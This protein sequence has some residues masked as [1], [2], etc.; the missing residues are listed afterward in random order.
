MTFSEMEGK[1]GVGVN[2]GLEK[3]ERVGMDRGRGK[4]RKRRR[5]KMYRPL[6]PP[7]PPLFSTSEGNL[8]S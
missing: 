3:V 2:V 5:R 8:Y 6:S 1:R 7:L 4:R